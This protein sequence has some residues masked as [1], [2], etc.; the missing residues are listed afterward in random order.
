MSLE[1]QTV[2]PAPN[3]R[4]SALKPLLWLVAAA[5]MAVCTLMLAPVPPL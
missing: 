1:A 3:P 2:P 4:P 5:A